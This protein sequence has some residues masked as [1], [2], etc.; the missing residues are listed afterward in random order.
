VPGS[1][2]PISISILNLLSLSPIL[3]SNLLS[4][5]YN[6]NL[7]SSI[8]ISNS[9]SNLSLQPQSPP[10]ISDAFLRSQSPMS[11]LQSPIS[12]LLSPN[13]VSILDILFQSPFSFSSL[14]LQSLCPI[15]ISNLQSYS[16][17][18]I[19]NLILQTQ[20]PIGSAG[21][22]EPHEEGVRAAAHKLRSA[23][24]RAALRYDPK[25]PTLWTPS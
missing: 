19:C 13:S 11:N 9:F 10:S 1:H 3:I 8:S 25:V 14:N 4:P 21:G 7:Q 12:N 6:L 22:K 24:L 20:S 18:S 15:F 23:E 16:A 17:I 2:S 5:I